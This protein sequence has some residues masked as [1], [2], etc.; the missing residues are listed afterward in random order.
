MA[1]RSGFISASI[2]NSEDGGRVVN[3]AQWAGK[4]DFE[5]MRTDL[6]AQVHMRDCAALAKSSIQ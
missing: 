6:E 1:H 2:H 3:Y 4:A 5:A